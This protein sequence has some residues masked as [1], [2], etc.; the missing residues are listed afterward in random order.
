[1]VNPRLTICYTK[2]CV[3]RINEWGKNDVMVY[4]INFIPNTFDVF[5]HR[6]MPLCVKK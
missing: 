5:F 6:K 1:M 4:E 2:E 3:C